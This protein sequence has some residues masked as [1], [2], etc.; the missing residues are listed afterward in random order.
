MHPPLG[1]SFAV[2][3]RRFLQLERKLQGN[4]ELRENYKSFMDKYLELGHMQ[5]VSEGEQR[6]TASHK[7]ATKM[8]FF[9]PHHAVL[10]HMP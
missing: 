3:E 2:A 10:K 1:D 8:G 5:L 9:L 4:Y 7:E 6:D